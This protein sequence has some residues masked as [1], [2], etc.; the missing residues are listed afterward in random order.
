MPRW[1]IVKKQVE[2]CRCDPTI[3]AAGRRLP[4]KE[5]LTATR[6]DNRPRSIMTRGV[7]AALD[8][9]FGGQARDPIMRDRRMVHQHP[10]VTPVGQFISIFSYLPS[11]AV[12]PLLSFTTRPTRREPDCLPIVIRASGGFRYKRPF[13]VMRHYACV[14]QRRIRAGGGII[15]TAVR[16]RAESASG[17]W[18]LAR[19]EDNWPKERVS[20]GL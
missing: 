5:H 3:A 7:I 1:A 11:S 13:G 2:V 17:A 14:V 19:M 4:R 16:F 18:A 10:T 8:G 15:G 9:R 6:S 20:R 12:G